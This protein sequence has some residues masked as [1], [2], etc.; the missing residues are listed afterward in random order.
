MLVARASFALI[1]TSDGRRFCGPQEEFAMP[2]ND[3]GD[4]ISQ[5]TR[6]CRVDANKPDFGHYPK[7]QVPALVT[8]NAL[9]ISYLERNVAGSRKCRARSFLLS[10]GLQHLQSLHATPISISNQL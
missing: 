10:L 4:H 9:H 6:K 2:L 5:T 1:G 3:S 8:L 7:V